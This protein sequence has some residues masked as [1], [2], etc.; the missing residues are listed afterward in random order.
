MLR[1]TLNLLVLRLLR[2]GFICTTTPEEEEEEEE[3][4]HLIVGRRRVT[5]LLNLTPRD[6]RS[7]ERF[8]HAVQVQQFSVRLSKFPAAPHL[9]LKTSNVPNVL[10]CLC[11]LLVFLW[12]TIESVQ[13]RAQSPPE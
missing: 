4:T 12:C 10:M 13:Q 1:L 3:R 9:G 7:A 8:S 2:I 6:G 11:E 5:A